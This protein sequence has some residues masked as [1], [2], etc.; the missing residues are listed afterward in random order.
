MAKSYEI[1]GQ[2]VMLPDDPND[3]GR[4]YDDTVWSGPSYPD[5]LD[6][7]LARIVALDGAAKIDDMEDVH[8][9]QRV[10]PVIE[11]IGLRN[12]LTI[13][14]HRTILGKKMSKVVGTLIA[15]SRSDQSEQSDSTR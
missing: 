13:Y 11:G 9:A 2:F 1:I 10:L 4:E 14:Q 12:E 5:E 7:E 6:V 8:Y 3:V 15:T